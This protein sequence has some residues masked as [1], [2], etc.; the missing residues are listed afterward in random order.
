MQ[1][2]LRL[3]VFITALI[4]KPQ[5]R[6]SRRNN[7]MQ[8]MGKVLFLWNVAG[9]CLY[10][11]RGIISQK[12]D[13]SLLQY[14][15]AKR[16]ETLQGILTFYKVQRVKSITK[17]FSV[18]CLLWRTIKKIWLFLLCYFFMKNAY[19]C[20]MFNFLSELKFYRYCYLSYTT[21]P[22]ILIKD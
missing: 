21:K 7:S 4:K 13:F 2:V 8:C 9:C 11:R 17:I 12:Y 10:L 20:F 6:R 14:V 18:Y 1:M 16:E 15:N 5:L 22:C 19:S 3:Y